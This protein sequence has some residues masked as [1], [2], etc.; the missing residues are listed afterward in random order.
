MRRSDWCLIFLPLTLLSAEP[1][2]PCGLC[3]EDD[4]AAVYSYESMEKVRLGP[5]R[6]EFLVMKVMG[7]FDP[8]A[9]ELVEKLQDW[10]AKRQGVDAASV[11]ISPNQRS[12]GF[13][14]EKVYSKGTLLRDLNQA[15][16]SEHFSVVE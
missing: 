16:P 4:R 11:I 6:L 12:I 10:L 15:F 7:S 1:T 2:Y 3:H 14:F 9:P 8:L 13:V 5:E